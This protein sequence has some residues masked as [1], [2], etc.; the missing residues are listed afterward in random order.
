MK[1][2][3]AGFHKRLM[4]FSHDCGFKKPI[5]HLPDFKDVDFSLTHFKFVYFEIEVSFGLIWVN[6]QND[7]FHLQ[8][9]IL[10]I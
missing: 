8:T 4:R 5:I 7:R 10:G 6:L 1:G 2:E 3:G 9:S